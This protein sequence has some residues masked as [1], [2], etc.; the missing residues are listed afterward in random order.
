MN[1]IATILTVILGLTTACEIMPRNTL[2]DCNAQCQDSKN[3]KACEAFCACI[4][5]NC[6][7][8]DSCLA[9]YEK[10]KTGK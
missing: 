9:E 3:P 7:S 2:K 1:A 4:H 8:L 10:A 6:K 5:Q